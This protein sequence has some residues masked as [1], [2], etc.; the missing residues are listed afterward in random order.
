[1]R[2]SVI[3]PAH[4]ADD[5]IGKAL[6]SVKKQRY[7][8]TDFEIIVI[9]DACED[10]TQGVAEAYGARTRAVNYHR[11]GLARNEGIE[12]AQGE[13]LLFL[14]DDD[15]WMHDM[16]LTAVDQML[17]ATNEPDVMIFGSIWKDVGY[18]SARMEGGYIWPNVW[19]KV[20]KRSFVGETRFSGKYSV[21]DLDFTQ[22]VLAKKP[23]LAES[24]FPLVYYNY[25][26]PGSM[27]EIG[28][29]SNAGHGESSAAL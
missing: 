5:R 19:S 29:R 13:Y 11:D 15:W 8:K 7:D 16:T 17:K 1:M 26:R 20:W 18:V 22:A 9:C 14:D 25:M 27:T 21:S 28:R 6:R 12:M 4:N 2:F 10:L 23:R 24:T 3:I